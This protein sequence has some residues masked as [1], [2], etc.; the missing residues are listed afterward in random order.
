MG[1]SDGREMTS[2]KSVY[3][4]MVRH[5]D[6][7][8]RSPAVIWFIVIRAQAVMCAVFLFLTVAGQVSL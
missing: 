2:A 1:I 4:A 8:G 3:L 6:L 5:T 7:I